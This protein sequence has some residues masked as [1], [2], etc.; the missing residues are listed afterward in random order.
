MTSP[1]FA[2]FKVFLF[3]QV[4]WSSTSPK[5]AR[6]SL[7]IVSSS[8]ST[9]ERDSNHYPI[10]FLVLPGRCKSR[11]Q[12]TCKWQVFLIFIG[13]VWLRD[14]RSGCDIRVHF[15]KFEEFFSYSLSISKTYRRSLGGFKV[16]VLLQARCLKRRLL[17]R[18]ISLRT[19]YV[20]HIWLRMKSTDGISHMWPGHGALW[21]YDM[22]KVLNFL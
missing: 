3:R 12:L 2:Y 15:S 20:C 4:L 10:C 8:P 9:Y 18:C 13:L 7:S 21:A 6:K 14:V 22:T 5:I 11:L 19:T 1:D 17:M 16:W